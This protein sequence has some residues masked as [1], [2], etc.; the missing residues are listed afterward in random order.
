MNI[1]LTKLFVLITVA[2]HCQFANATVSGP[3]NNLT[4]SFSINWTGKSYGCSTGYSAYRI[5]EYVN[6]SFTKIYYVSNSSTKY[7]SFANK[8]SASY[9]YQVY[10]AVCSGSGASY[11]S[12]GSKDVYVLSSQNISRDVVF[13]HTDLLGSPVAETDLKGDLN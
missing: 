13:I 12:T 11:I 4:G 2:C 7:Y 6:G 9:T 10:Y 5:R 3:G 8:P 1:K